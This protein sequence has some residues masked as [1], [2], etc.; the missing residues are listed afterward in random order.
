LIGLP[1]G[2]WMLHRQI[3]LYSPCSRKNIAIQKLVTN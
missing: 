2:R 3:Q 1:L